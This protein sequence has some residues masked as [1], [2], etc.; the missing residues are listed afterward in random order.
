MAGFAI[1]G[2]VIKSSTTLGGFDPFYPKLWAGAGDYQ[3]PEVDSCLGSVD[4]DS[5][6]YSYSI[7]SPCLLKQST[8]DDE[9]LCSQF[10]ECYEDLKGY[11]LKSY[12]LQS[13]EQK[14]LQDGVTVL[15]IAKD[16]HMII[17][18]YKDG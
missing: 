9:S 10:P 1:D 15:G 6:F 7:L 8:I 3:L 18:P 16:G 13:K 17:G 14:N 4:Q 2:V 12:T 5:L 11:A